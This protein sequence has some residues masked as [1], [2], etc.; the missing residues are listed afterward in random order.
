MRRLRL[1]ARLIASLGLCL[2]SLAS[3]P[4]SAQVDVPAPLEPWRDWVLYGQ[5]H[6]ACPVLNGSPADQAASFVCAWPG[7]IA[8]DVVAGGAQFRIDWTTYAE[9]WVPL[10]GNDRYWPADV[11]VDDEAGEALDQY[12]ILLEDQAFPLEDKSIQIHVANVKQINGGIY[13]EWVKK[14][15]LQLRKLQPARYAKDEKVD[16]YVQAIY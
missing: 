14:S 11:T 15:L 12:R 16:N 13:D 9:S 3:L 8:V 1:I 2:G 6:L 10:P 7:E 4:T 5:E